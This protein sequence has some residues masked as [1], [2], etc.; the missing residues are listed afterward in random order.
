VDG[1]SPIPDKP[2]KTKRKPKARSVYDCGC[3]KKVNALLAPKN[4]GVEVGMTINFQ[5]GSQGDCLRIATFKLDGKKKG[6]AVNL[7]ALF[8]PFCGVKYG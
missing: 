5:D 8:C 4:T 6:R 2:S 3:I 1:V 7:L